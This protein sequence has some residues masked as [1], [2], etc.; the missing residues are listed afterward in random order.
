MGYQIFSSLSYGR[1]F[2][3]VTNHNPL[4]W[5]DNARDPH[6]RLS[7]WSLGLQS[8][9]FKIKHR[10]GKSHGNVDAL[11]RIPDS[12]AKLAVPLVSA[13]NASGLQLEY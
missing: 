9:S 13:V 5:L 2:D 1:S 8:S 12:S 4:K 11:S 10:P 7:R 3:V 6:S